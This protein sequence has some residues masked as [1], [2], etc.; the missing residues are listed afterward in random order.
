MIVAELSMAFWLNYASE[1]CHKPR[2]MQSFWQ[3]FVVVIKCGGLLCRHL[4]DKILN[5]L[6]HREMVD[7]INGYSSEEPIFQMN[8]RIRNVQFISC[9]C[10]LYINDGA[11]FTQSGIFVHHNA[12]RVHLSE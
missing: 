6:K 3:I 5:L 7:W 11:G 10:I 4:N 9:S 1:L 8:D 12:V 2:I